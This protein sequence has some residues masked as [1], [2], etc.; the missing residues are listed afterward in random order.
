MKGGLKQ[1][2]RTEK[3]GSE[4]PEQVSHA[5]G[6][7]FKC[8]RIQFQINRILQMSAVVDVFRSEDRKNPMIAIKTSCQVTY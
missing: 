5:T 4:K 1:S 7:G 3:P 6:F 8:F 2:G